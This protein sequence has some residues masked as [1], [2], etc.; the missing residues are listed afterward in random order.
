[1]L[2]QLT[3]FG[4]QLN[5]VK[6]DAGLP[7]IQLNPGGNRQTG[8]KFRPVV[9]VIFENFPHYRLNIRKINDDGAAVRRLD[10]RTDEMTFSHT[11]SPLDQQGRS[12]LRLG[13]PLF[14]LLQCLTTEFHSFPP[15]IYH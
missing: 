3:G 9:G 5:F 6:N 11:T 13:F 1:M 2:H 14:Q 15:N 4:I 12:S 8:E 10:K 7:R